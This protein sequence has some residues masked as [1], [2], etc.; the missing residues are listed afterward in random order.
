MK[1]SPGT[2]CTYLFQAADDTTLF[3]NYCNIIIRLS[4]TQG[5][6]AEEYEEKAQT[7]TGSLVMLDNRWK[8][9]MKRM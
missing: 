4:V 5:L 7:E 2:Q 1:N 3:S 8:G 6:R 9:L